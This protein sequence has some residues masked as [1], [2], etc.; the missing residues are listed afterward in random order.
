MTN[1]REEHLTADETHLGPSQGVSSLILRCGLNLSQQTAYLVSS[2]SLMT[3]IQ[4][5]I[6]CRGDNIQDPTDQREISKPYEHP[7]NRSQKIKR[8]QISASLESWQRIQ[9]HI[10]GLLSS[11]MNR[12]RLGSL[13]ESGVFIRLR[14]KSPFLSYI[15]T[16]RVRTCWG[17]TALWQTFPSTTP[18]A[19]SSTLC[20]SIEWWSFGDLTGGRASGFGPTS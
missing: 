14:V 9:T 10:V 2:R 1:Q 19:P 3:L 4:G 12:P 6:E 15:C 18:R 11:T 7:L 5:E 13:L 17:G 8:S 16:G 20:S